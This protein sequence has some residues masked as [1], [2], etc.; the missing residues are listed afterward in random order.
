MWRCD[1][2]IYDVFLCKD[3][4]IGVPLLPL[5]IYGIKFI[6]N[7]YFGEIGGVNRLFQA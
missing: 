3:V 1:N 2:V 6:K 7:P 5:P 4:P